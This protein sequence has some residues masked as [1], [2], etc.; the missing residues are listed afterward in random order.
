MPWNCPSYK[1][2]TVS[3]YIHLKYFIHSPHH[4]FTSL[5]IHL[6]IHSPLH[7]PLHSF[8]SSFIRLTIYHPV[9][10]SFISSFNHLIHSSYHSFISPF[11]HLTIHSSHHSFTSNEASRWTRSSL[12]S[13]TF[14]F[15]IDFV[16]GFLIQREIL[17]LGTSQSNFFLFC[18]V[19]MILVYIL[20]HNWNMG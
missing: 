20:F 9:F 11:I 17:S 8:A 5:S 19:Y 3:S 2:L 12:S 6:F 14:L 16:L 13:F 7:S 1:W 10:H 15:L 4:S 18:Q